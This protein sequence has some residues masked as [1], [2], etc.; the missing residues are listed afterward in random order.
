[1]KVLVIGGGIGGFATA[2]SLHAV[3]IECEVFEPRSAVG[4]TV[5]VWFDQEEGAALLRLVREQQI[6]ARSKPMSPAPGGEGAT[7]R[8][9]VGRWV[10]GAGVRARRIAFDLGCGIVSA[11]I[12]GPWRAHDQ[13]G[14]SAPR[15]PVVYRS[16]WGEPEPCRAAG[17]T[18][19]APPPPSRRRDRRAVNDRDRE[20]PPAGALRS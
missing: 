14:S 7:G 3:G 8:T 15:R 5:H 12:T 9:G 20:H 4:R 16:T 1:M 13:H 17:A 11:R 6:G 19:A 2:L 10:V 18:L